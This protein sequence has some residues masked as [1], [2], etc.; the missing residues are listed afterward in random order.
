M[1]MATEAPAVR[2]MKRTSRTAR[3]EDEGAFSG[4]SPS[5]THGRGFRNCLPSLFEED[6]VRGGE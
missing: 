3:G 5:L 1:R 6:G 2:S 4:I